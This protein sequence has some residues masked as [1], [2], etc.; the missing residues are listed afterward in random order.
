MPELR[1]RAGG[2][3][4]DHAERGVL[5]P[6]PLRR[7]ALRPAGSSRGRREPERRGGDARDPR[8]RLRRRGQAPD[9]PRH[10]RPVQRLLRRLLRPGAEGAH[11]D[12][13]RLRRRRSRRP[14]CW[15]PR[16]PRPPPS[17]SA[18]S[19]TTRSRCTST[20]SPP[21][22]PTS[23]AYPGISLPA[24]LAPE[25]GL[26]VGFQVL[27]PALADDRLY[28]VGA[29][30]EAL[31]EQNVGWPAA[32]DATTACDDPDRPGDRM[33]DRTLLSFED[34]LDAVRP[35]DGPGGP[36][37]AEHRDQDVLRL[38]DRVRCRA[39]HP[40]LPDLPGPA[41]LAAGGQRQGGRVGDPDRAGAELR[42]RR[43]VPLRPEELLLP[44]HA[45][46]LPDLPVRRAD[47]L[48]RLDRRRV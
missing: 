22:R 17:R 9:H 45:E 42:D 8:R 37:R 43:V 29:A 19:S 28:R 23:P 36:R 10:L 25:D 15:S 11:P 41:R 2:V 12:Q 3:L 20:T 38:P 48:R 47:R 32:S 16:P 31:L 27:A 1:A 39:E 6:R 21:S 34:A 13:P 14:T 4:P 44:G 7:D 26:P 24:G 46:E 35:G 33:T 5:E 40:D 30:L 18:R